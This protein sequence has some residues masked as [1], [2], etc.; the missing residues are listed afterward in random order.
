M[1]EAIALDAGVLSQVTHPRPHPALTNWFQK[2]LQ[3]NVTVFIPEIADYEVRRELLRA[4]KATGVARLDQLKSALAYLPVTTAVMLHAAQLW[5]DARNRGRPTADPSELDCDVVL[6]AQ[7][8]AVGATVVTDN[9]GHL[10]LFVEA[11]RW[12]EV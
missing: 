2:I 7:A 5:A 4:G 3:T 9:I 10:A 8:L 6:A 12:R 11:K 1:A